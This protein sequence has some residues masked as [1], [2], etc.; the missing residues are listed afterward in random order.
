[1]E[2]GVHRILVAV[3]PPSQPKLHALLEDS[4]ADFFESY[5][6]A[7]RALDHHRYAAAVVGLHFGESRMFDF[8][9]EVKS[10]QPW[11]RVLCVQG[12]AGQLGPGAVTSLAPA[13]EALGVEGPVDLSKLTEDECRGIAHVLYWAGSPTVSARP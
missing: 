11:A 12:T 4:E 3:S 8:V 2:S 5:P 6:D 13:L 10:R 7:E 9:R 1:M